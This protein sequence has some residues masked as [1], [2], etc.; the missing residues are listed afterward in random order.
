MKRILFAGIMA[1][2]IFSACSKD[3]DYHDASVCALQMKEKFKDRL[4]CTEEP[5]M[6]GNLYIGKYNSEI[7]YFVDIVCAACNTVPP[8]YGYNCKNEKITFDSFNDVLDVRQIYNSCTN[9]F[10]E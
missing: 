10:T 3:D 5:Y 6:S 7:V 4:M 2:L 9:K 1:T 8:Q